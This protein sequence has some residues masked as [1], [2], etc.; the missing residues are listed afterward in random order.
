M[1]AGWIPVEGY[2][3][4]EQT[5]EGNNE[6]DLADLSFHMPN[7]PLIWVQLECPHDG[8]FGGPEGVQS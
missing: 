1:A 2:V 5:S 7:G 3:P 4:G 6:Y 8:A